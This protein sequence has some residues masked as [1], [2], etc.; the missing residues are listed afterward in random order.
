MK[1]T[2]IANR[3]CSA[4]YQGTVR[5]VQTGLC[6]E[7]QGY[8]QGALAPLGPLNPPWTRCLTCHLS[9]PSALRRSPDDPTETKKE[10]KFQTWPQRQ[11]AYT[12]LVYPPD[13]QKNIYKKNR[14]LFITTTE[15]EL[16]I[17]G[18]NRNYSFSLSQCHSFSVENGGCFRLHSR[19]SC[20][21]RSCWCDQIRPELVTFLCLPA[22]KS[23]GAA[24][25]FTL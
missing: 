1:Q 20:W 4:S 18:L 6:S 12:T 13:R 23:A 8:R 5:R 24:Q 25:K 3:L 16:K 14:S 10:V 2:F 11:S 19:S 22:L 9:L 17:C 7:P 21:P 15:L